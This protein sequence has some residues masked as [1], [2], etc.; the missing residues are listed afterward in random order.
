M[1]RMDLTIVIPAH[2]EEGII[3]KTLESLKRVVKIRHKIIIVN[4]CSTD[5][6][7][8]VINQYAKKNENV[9]CLRTTPK[10]RGFANALKKGFMAVS[11]GAVIPVMADLCDEPQTI[12]KMYTQIQKDWDVVCGSRYMKGGRKEGGPILQHYLSFFV[13]RSLQ[14][15]TGVPTSDVS[16]AFKMYKKEWLDK[17]EMNPISGVEASMELLFQMYFGNAKITEVPTKWKGRTVGKSKFKI[18]ERTPRYSRIYLWAL[19]NA[20]RKSFSL[21]LKNF[22]I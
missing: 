8:Q 2:N 15:L 13:C 4:D 20:F 22:Y 6:T 7:E 10:T 18:F 9:I 5:Q 14:F 1:L 16:N 12:N 19:E 3:I 11:A 17:V 21:P